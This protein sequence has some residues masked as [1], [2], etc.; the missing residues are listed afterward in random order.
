MYVKPNSTYAKF[1]HFTR[2]IHLF[3]RDTKKQIAFYDAISE[4]ENQKYF[5]R[6]TIYI[7]AAYFCMNFN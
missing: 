7:F 3:R 5:T 2:L 6:K 1:Q 4:K